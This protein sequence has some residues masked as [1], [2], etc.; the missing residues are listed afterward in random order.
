LKKNYNVNLDNF[1]LYDAYITT[2]LLFLTKR[3]RFQINNK[4][5][6]TV[7]ITMCHNI[8]LSCAK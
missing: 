3:Y 8:I 5:S 2:I 7:E 4:V 6:R 1:C